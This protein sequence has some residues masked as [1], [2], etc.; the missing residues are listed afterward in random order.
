MKRLRKK[1]TGVKIRFFCCGEYGPKL[2]R[3]HYHLILFGIDFDDKILFKK[4]KSGNLYTSKVL[5]DCWGKGY[6]TTGAVTLQSAG[7]VARYCLKKIN[8]QMAD[9]HYLKIDS[10]TGECFKLKPEFATMSRRPGIASDWF[11]KYSGDV[12]PKD[13][14]T[15]GGK[16]YRPPKYYDKLFED[17]NPDEYSFIKDAR[18]DQ[19]LEFSVDNTPERLAVKDVCLKSK[20]KKLIR[21]YEDGSSLPPSPSF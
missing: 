16:K 7:Y 20:V 15:V 21:H 10:D 4:S 17:M 12:Y 1:F 3:P 13:F 18:V 2:G 9:A 5:S 14:V 6:V 19:S 8:G 11:K